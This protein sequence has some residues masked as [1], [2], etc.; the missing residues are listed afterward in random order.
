MEFGDKECANALCHCA[1]EPG[2]DYC[3]Q[4]C[5]KAFGETDCN[6]GHAECRAEA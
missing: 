4:A 2:S 6:C 5:E 1:P 3:S